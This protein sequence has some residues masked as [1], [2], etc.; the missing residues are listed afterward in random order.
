MIDVPSTVKKAVTATIAF[1]AILRLNIR[2]PPQLEKNCRTGPRIAKPGS[3]AAVFGLLC[4]GGNFAGGRVGGRYFWI[5]S[6]WFIAYEFGTAGLVRRSAAV[7][8]RGA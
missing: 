7:R 4:P 6:A 2:F 5:G 8:R 1:W 3:I